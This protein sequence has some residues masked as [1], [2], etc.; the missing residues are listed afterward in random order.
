LTIPRCSSDAPPPHGPRPRGPA[1]SRRAPQSRSP[2]SPAD[3]VSSW[4]ES[5]GRPARRPTVGGPRSRVRLRDPEA[6]R[7]GDPREQVGVVPVKVDEFVRCSTC[8]SAATRGIID[9][10]GGACPFCLSVIVKPKSTTDAVRLVE[11]RPTR[12]V[13]PS[14]KAKGVPAELDSIILKCLSYEPGGRYGIGREGQPWKRTQGIRSTE[15][16][17]S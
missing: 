11:P 5:H 17:G 9:H 7:P 1:R 16:G 12:I 15:S 6:H 14:V 2:P 10:F 4:A 13:P 8:D 3:V